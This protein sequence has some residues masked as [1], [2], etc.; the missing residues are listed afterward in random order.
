[1]TRL[2]Y[3]SCNGYF[4]VVRPQTDTQ[5]RTCVHRYDNGGVNIVL[6][7]DW[8][9]KGLQA[10]THAVLYIFHISTSNYINSASCNYVGWFQEVSG[11]IMRL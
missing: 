3:R 7:Y 8:L 6:I 1:M 9:L 11:L 4:H 10:I 5:R 2:R